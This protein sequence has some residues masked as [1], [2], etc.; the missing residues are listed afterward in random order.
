MRRLISSLFLLG[1]VV[2][3]YGCF[4]EKKSSQLDLWVKGEGK[5]KVLSTTA[6]IGNLVEQI[7]KERVSYITLIN[8][9]VDP[10]SYTPAKADDAKFALADLI[11]TN[12]L[13]LECSCLIALNRF[14]EK[15]V[16]VGDLFEKE[17]PKQIIFVGHEKDP[18]IWM[19]LSIWKNCCSYIAKTLAEKDP[20]GAAFYEHNSRVLIEQMEQTDREMRTLFDSVDQKYRYL[21]AS[22]DA[23]NYFTR[24]YLATEEEMQNGKWEE[25]FIAP[26]GINPEGQLSVQHLQRVID[27]V[28]KHDVKVLFPESCLN[29]SALETIVLNPAVRGAAL[30]KMPLYSDALGSIKVEDGQCRYLVVMMYNA[31]T[32]VEEWKA[33][34]G[35]SY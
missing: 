22:H 29:P 12:G 19:D 20:E 31:K 15:V 32:I 35:L 1:L 23:F 18:H 4:N 26:D 21:V 6:M 27:F 3:L 34:Y 2:S 30:S 10:H 24:R 7:G 14:K 11:Y 28:K 33:A 5:I 8:D 9:E 17:Q 16:A 25:R 13:G